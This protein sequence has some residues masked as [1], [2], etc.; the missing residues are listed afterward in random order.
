MPAALADP[1]FR[2]W[3]RILGLV[4]AAPLP[5]LAAVLGYHWMA[6]PPMEELER[7]APSLITRV[8]DKDSA[9]IREFYVERRIWT[10]L[11]KVP[12]RQIRAVL[13]IE[14]QDFFRHSGVDLKAIPASL[15]PALTGG[16][17]RGGSTLTQQLAKLLFL[18]SERS[19]SRKIKE[20]LLAVRIERTY[21]KKEILEFYLNQVYLGAG[22][23]GFASASQ[24]YFSLPLDSLDLS[25]QALLAGLMQR[26]EALRPDR[27]PEAARARRN[28]VLHVM[29]GTGAVGDG[30]ADS[31]SALPLGLRLKTFEP[32]SGVAAAYF[33]GTLR[34][35]IEE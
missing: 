13:A 23:H 2:K 25:R 20:M 21:T 35:E 9:L 1:E 32:L 22:A 7:I 33:V 11:E 18:G 14:D 28:T 19:L 15:V 24:R 34:K 27:F 10:P 16:R 31:A 26:P 4:F 6:L 8:Y 3:L 30:S 29:A 5:I 17:I 12:E